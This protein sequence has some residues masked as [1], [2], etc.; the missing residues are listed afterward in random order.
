M[1]AVV[2]CGNLLTVGTLIVSGDDEIQFAAKEKLPIPLAGCV[3]PLCVLALPFL[4]VS[5]RFLPS[6]TYSAPASGFSSTVGLQYLGR[7]T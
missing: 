5:S 1:L 6:P 7:I 3:L 4:V 2:G